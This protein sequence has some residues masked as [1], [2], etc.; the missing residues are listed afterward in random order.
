MKILQKKKAGSSHI[1]VLGVLVLISV[2]TVYI[3]NV[4]QN[5]IYQINAYSLQMQGYYLCHE[6]TSAA[7]SA[8]LEGDDEA[9]IYTNDFPMTDSMTHTFDDEEIGES[10]ITMSKEQHPYYE[11][12]S[13]AWIVIDVTTTIRDSRNGHSSDFTYMTT[14]LV[15]V[16]NPIIQLFNKDPSELVYTPMETTGS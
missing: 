9:L 2:F 12:E 13:T 8:L 14:S 5:D 10:V 4:L 3:I 7:I 16:D 15:L 1:I 11:I 6:A